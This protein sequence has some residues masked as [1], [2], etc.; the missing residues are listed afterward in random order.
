MGEF[1]HTELRNQGNNGEKGHSLVPLTMTTEPTALGEKPSSIKVGS[2][3]DS[4]PRPS[5]A[6]TATDN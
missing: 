4:G 3:H 5:V 6:P 1:E 2:T